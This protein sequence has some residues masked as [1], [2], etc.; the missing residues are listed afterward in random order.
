MVDWTYA[1]NSRLLVSFQ[2]DGF[3]R[4]VVPAAYGLN[5]RTGNRLVRAYQVGGGDATRSIPT[6]S[7]FNAD[8]VV[9]GSVTSD[10]FDADPPGYERNDSAMDVI[11]AQ[12]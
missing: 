2:Y 1:I 11:Y 10:H 4:L 6:W 5:Q 12:L 8:K 7:L 9:S 3:P